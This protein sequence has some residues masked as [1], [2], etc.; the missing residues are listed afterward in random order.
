MQRRAKDIGDLEFPL[1]ANIP[2]EVHRDHD[3]VG[4]QAEITPYADRSLRPLRGEEV[5]I[6]GVVVKGSQVAGYEAKYGDRT[7]YGP[8]KSFFVQYA[9]VEDVHLDSD[10]AK[11]IRALLSHHN[12]QRDYY[13]SSWDGIE[14]LHFELAKA[15][16]VAAIE[17]AGWYKYPSSSRSDMDGK[18]WRLIVPGI[19]GA[20]AV[21]CHSVLHDSVW[22]LATTVYS[23][24]DIDM[25]ELRFLG[26]PDHWDRV[27]V[28][29][30]AV[31]QALETDGYDYSEVARVLAA[32][33]RGNQ[34]L[35]DIV[36][37]LWQPIERTL[38]NLFQ[39]DAR[40]APLSPGFGTIRVEPNHVGRYEHPSD[41]CVYGI[42]TINPSATKDQRY[43][44]EVVKHEMI[45]HALAS[46][47]GKRKPHDEDFQR[48]AKALGLPKK[49]RD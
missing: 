13:A 42:L 37:R 23:T 26:H 33:L 17:S 46:L 20:V 34:A 11:H 15:S 29:T 43:L 36:R 19:S 2:E 22:T 21:N 3:D 31:A 28:W 1:E 40:M 10:K 7:V 39:T 8:K 48:M 27:L 30:L 4:K 16:Q 18:D 49:Y 38:Q 44:F 12:Q 14:A 41:E 47:P 24:R 32:R 5:T 35:K 25:Q 9:M 45:H 6:T